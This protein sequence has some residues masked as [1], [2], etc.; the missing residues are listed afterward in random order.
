MS[1]YLVDTNVILRLAMQ[2]EPTYFVQAKAFFRQVEQKEIQ[3]ELSILVVLEYLWVSEKY[4]RVPREEACEVLTDL[5]QLSNFK[6]KEMKK[7]ELI[8]ILDRYQSS[9]Y[10]FT[11]VYLSFFSKAQVEVM[12]FDND[13]VKLTGKS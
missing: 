5:L 4:Y 8:K 11:D 10:D 13:L 7:S 1:R 2:D 12:S 6:V 9:K 3:A